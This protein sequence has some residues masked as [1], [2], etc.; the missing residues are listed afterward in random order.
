M[1]FVIL[2]FVAA[3]A[4]SEIATRYFEHLSYSTCDPDLV[5]LRGVPVFE[6]GD[7]EWSDD[8]IE[9]I[10]LRHPEV[11]KDG[12]WVPSEIS[13]IDVLVFLLDVFNTGGSFGEL[14]HDAMDEEQF[15][16]LSKMILK[17]G[18]KPS[19]FSHRKIILDK[20]AFSLAYGTNVEN[21]WLA[22]NKRALVI[23]NTASDSPF[24]VDKPWQVYTLGESTQSHF[25]VDFILSD[26]P[27]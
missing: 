7:F 13:K 26:C 14:L 23:L 6:H 24:L 18:G 27:K 5:Q 21:H 3:Q 12:E 17:N 4:K 10:T 8:R 25:P 19:R 1:T 11:L 20:A 2:L 15:Q 9:T 22:N 16:S